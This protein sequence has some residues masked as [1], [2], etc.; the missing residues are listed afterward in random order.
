MSNFSIPSILYI[1]TIGQ[2]DKPFVPEDENDIRTP[3]PDLL[4]RPYAPDYDGES[5][6]NQYQNSINQI[7]YSQEN[8]NDPKPTYGPYNVPVQWSTRHPNF[9]ISTTQPTRTTELFKPLRSA[10]RRRN[11]V[12]NIPASNSDQSKILLDLGVSSSQDS[13]R[14][15]PESSFDNSVKIEQPERPSLQYTP[16]YINPRY[17]LNY[18]DS[19]S[20]TESSYASTSTLSSVQFVSST[21]APATTSSKIS[22]AAKSTQ[23]V[24]TP[25]SK[26]SSNKDYELSKQNNR[27]ATKFNQNGKDRTKTASEQSRILTRPSLANTDGVPVDSTAFPPND[28]V[29]QPAPSFVPIV[30]LSHGIQKPATDLIPP[31]ESFHYY[32]DATTQGPPIYFEWKIPA[33]GLEPPKFESRSNDYSD[34]EIST[35]ES[36]SSI[37]IPTESLQLPKLNNVSVVFRTPPNQLEPPVEQDA[38]TRF[39]HNPF[40]TSALASLS[41]TE[42]LKGK[43]PTPRSISASE[44]KLQNAVVDGG[45]VLKDPKDNNYLDLK[46]LLLIPDYT[47]PLE[48][49]G[50]PSYQQA[51]SVNSFQIRIPDKTDDKPW[52]GENAECP[53]C[54][55]SFLKPGK[56][57]PCIKIRR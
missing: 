22:V 41:S 2:R 20:T 30:G 24:I 5:F 6:R 23:G 25:N 49:D 18:T 32:D 15:Q 33:S 12:V 7:D 54:H 28:S 4:D 52:Y 40:L 16:P 48:V 42:K 53:E 45:N 46:K 13:R 36:S 27:G 57:E 35:T 14:S 51:N 1:L 9:P 56:C 21:S 10:I 19:G 39:A 26:K 37:S 11:D 44:E 31:Y 17:D 47:F 55:P 38:F 50:R 34:N 3:R 43:S 29:Q 8:K